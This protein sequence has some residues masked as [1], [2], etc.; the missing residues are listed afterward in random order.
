VSGESIELK[1]QGAR[2]EMPLYVARPSGEG[3]WPGVLVISDA[4]GMTTDLRNQ[5]DWLAGEG[6]LAVAPD[7]Y[8]WGG[9]LR[10]M[11]TAMRQFSAGEGEVF[12]D[13]AVVHDWLGDHEDCAGP[14]GVIG[15]C[16]GGGFALMLAVKGGYQAS[17]V[18]YGDVP[19]E[20]LMQMADA[21]PVVASYGELDRT[22]TEAPGRLRDALQAHGVSHDVKVYPET[23]HGFLNDHPSDEMPLWALITG[24]LASTAYHE[25]SAS[26]ARRRIAAF[27]ETHLKGRV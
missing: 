10:C 21:C 16:M 6:Y 14:I 12:D 27:F 3:P 13:L 20:A 17:S 11:F 19:D 25:E 22:L 26:D 9:R 8:Y 24:R 15:F 23:G 18:N 2:G 7:L 5:A 4:L 1:I